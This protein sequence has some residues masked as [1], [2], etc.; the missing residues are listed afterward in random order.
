V[1]DPTV[2]ILPSLIATA[3]AVESRVSSVRIVPEAKIKSGASAAG[4]AALSTSAIQKAD[5]LKVLQLALSRKV[6]Y[7]TSFL[8][9]FD[10]MDVAIVPAGA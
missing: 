5:A 1:S 3:S 2:R 8:Y 4:L 10:A 6:T 7:P 9:V